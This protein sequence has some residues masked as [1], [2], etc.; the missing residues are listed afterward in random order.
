MGMWI[1]FIRKF[2]ARTYTQISQKAI[3]YFSLIHI[4]FGLISYYLSYFIMMLIG[5]PIDFISGMGLAYVMNISLV[6]E[7][8]EN[9]IL[10]KTKLKKN[11]RKDSLQNSLMDLVFTEIGGIIGFLRLNIFLNIIIIQNIITLGL[12]WR[13]VTKKR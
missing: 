3:D 13:Y 9:F 7:F 11:S 4:L 6:W 12:L 10:S 1:T 2:V 8:F 5:L